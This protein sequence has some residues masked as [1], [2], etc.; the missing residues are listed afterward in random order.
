MCWAG[1]SERIPKDISQL[2]SLIFPITAAGVISYRVVNPCLKKFTVELPDNPKKARIIGSFLLVVIPVVLYGGNTL[3]NLAIATPAFLTNGNQN[4]PNNNQAS[5]PSQFRHDVIK[6]IQQDINN[7]NDK[8]KKQRIEPILS[9]LV[10]G[11]LSQQIQSRIHT[12]QTSSIEKVT[13][14]EIEQGLQA[15]KKQLENNNWVVYERLP[16]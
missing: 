10:S 16:S 8:L 5:D 12:V 15:I 1:I 13:K 11:Q 9:E 6:A 14:T 3:K 2:A 4:T 7:L